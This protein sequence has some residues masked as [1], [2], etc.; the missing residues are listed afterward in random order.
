METMRVQTPCATFCCAW[1]PNRQDLTL[2]K[3]G[4][5]ISQIV[6]FSANSKLLEM[7]DWRPL[8]TAL[9]PFCV[10]HLAI[11]V[12]MNLNLRHDRLT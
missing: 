6:A 8:K 10:D 2:W 4:K 5:G 1:D 9:G 12:N 7:V 11:A 3:Q